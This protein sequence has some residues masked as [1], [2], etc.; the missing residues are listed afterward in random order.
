MA[1]AA[2]AA[3]GL[4]RR[5]LIIRG[6]YRVKTEKQWIPLCILG[7]HPDNRARVYPMEDTCV[8]LGLE[9]IFSGVSVDEANR[10]GVCVQE[11]PA[12]EQRNVRPS[13][14]GVYEAYFAYNKRKTSA[15]A[16]LQT[17][18]NKTL[19]MSYG[20]LSHSHLLLILLAMSTGAKWPILKGS[21][22]ESLKKLQDPDGRWNMAALT[23][24]DENFKELIK[25]GLRMEVLSWKMLI[26][27]PDACSLISQA[28]QKGCEFALRTSEITALSAVAGAVTMAKAER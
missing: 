3:V 5:A 14:G 11:V 7:V 4:V 25:N 20:T 9:I 1:T 24:K 2:D 17:C 10:E 15:V 19:A 8:N 26:E 28:M 12:E 13:H 18:F 21:Q 16:A 27:E 6:K 23:A 22:Y